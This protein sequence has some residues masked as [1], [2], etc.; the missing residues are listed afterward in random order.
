MVPGF[1]CPVGKRTGP[2]SVTS[3]IGRPTVAAPSRSPTAAA[4][5]SAHL[6]PKLVDDQERLPDPSRRQL[7]LAASSSRVVDRDPP[8][9][10]RPRAPGRD[11]RLTAQPHLESIL[12]RSITVDPQP[13][14]L[15][16][17]TGTGSQC[18]PRR[19]PRCLDD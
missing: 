14:P 1:L 8:D 17:R 18:P 19:L 15:H 11:R 9:P 3:R 13:E 5:Y 12:S 6:H 10:G 2:V 16:P 4:T 7:D